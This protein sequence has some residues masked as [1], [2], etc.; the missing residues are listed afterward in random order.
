MRSLRARC[1]AAITLA[2]VVPLA[3]S[4]PL[5]CPTEFDATGSFRWW[6]SSHYPSC[7][8]G[9]SVSALFDCAITQADASNWPNDYEWK[10]AECVQYSGENCS[11]ILAQV[12]CDEDRNPATPKTRSCAPWSSAPTSGVTADAWTGGTSQAPNCPEADCEPLMN[13]RQL[14]SYTGGAEY[15]PPAD[16]CV[17]GCAAFKRDVQTTS[18][19]TRYW[20]V[21]DSPTQWTYLVSYQFTGLQCDQQPDVPSNQMTD[22][23]EKCIGDFCRGVQTGENC[24]F[25]NDKWTCVSQVS[26]DR[27][28]KNADGSML[29]AE[30]APTPPKPDN[31]TPGV[32]ATP[33]ATVEA[34]TGAN[35]CQQINQYTSTTV[36]GSSRPVPDGGDTGGS[37]PIGGGDEGTG[38]G[39]G[40][41]DDGFGDP[42]AGPEL[43]EVC[44]FEECTNG[45]MASIASGPLGQSLSAQSFAVAGAACP[46]PT[47]SGFGDSWDLDFHCW[48]F[49]EYRGL[50]AALFLFGWTVTAAR[51]FL[52]A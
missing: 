38:T 14:G 1:L 10:D 42:F 2:F 31:G 43:G 37:G 8:E 26:P 7:G 35:S 27:C 20:R 50:F 9:T 13:Q 24:G 52:S 29:C 21:K 6:V 23:G 45:F 19:P 41:G 17:E 49:E 12:W 33:D 4:A 48:L 34:C 39:D 44:T 46:S 11:K 18:G 25:L 32:P 30:A 22:T 15:S 28:F 5:N 16:I 40:D 47:I 3:W 51:V 36:S